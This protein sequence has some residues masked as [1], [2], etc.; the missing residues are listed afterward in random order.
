MGSELI[1]YLRQEIQDR[2]ILEIRVWH[3]RDDRYPARLKYSLACVDRLTSRKVV[4]DNHFP[5]DPHLHLDDV[6]IPY[7]FSGISKLLDD[8]RD[9]VKDHFGDIL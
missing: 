5:K 7:M 8:F 2:Y 4:M 1:E 6:E 9:H 3:V